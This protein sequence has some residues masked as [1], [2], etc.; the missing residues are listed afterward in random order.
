MNIFTFHN[1]SI[2]SIVLSR[3]KSSEDVFTFHNVS[4][5]SLSTVMIDCVVS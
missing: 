5:N 3:R 2:N 4:I 1:V